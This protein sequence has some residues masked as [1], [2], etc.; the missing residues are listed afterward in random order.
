MI[1]DVRVVPIPIWYF[2]ILF[3]VSEANM[4]IQKNYSETFLEII[5][6]LKTFLKVMSLKALN[7]DLHR[8]R[9]YAN[10]GK[11]LNKFIKL[12]ILVDKSYNLVCQYST[13]QINQTCL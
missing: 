4:L 5:L 11:L 2:S 12:G 13:T 8:H 6:I 9:R 10:H 7:M 1:L 3:Q